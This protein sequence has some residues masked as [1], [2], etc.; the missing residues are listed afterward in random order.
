[1]TGGSDLLGLMRRQASD[2]DEQPPNEATLG[3]SAVRES[4]GPVLVKT[5]GLSALW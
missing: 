3:G 1:M 5:E 4:C 2:G